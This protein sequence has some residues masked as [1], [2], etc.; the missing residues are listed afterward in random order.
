[1]VIF[2]E[3]LKNV[4]LDLRVVN[5]GSVQHA[6]L[7]YSTAHFVRFA[8]LFCIAAEAAQNRQD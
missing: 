8:V 6:A 7:P 5:L 1:M 2:A 4:Q 3:L